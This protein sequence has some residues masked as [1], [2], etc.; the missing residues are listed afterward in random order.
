MLPVGIELY[1]GIE[2]NWLFGEN[3]STSEKS[4]VH[5]CLVIATE[6]AATV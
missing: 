3:V 1:G 2:Q 5:F 6:M 4:E